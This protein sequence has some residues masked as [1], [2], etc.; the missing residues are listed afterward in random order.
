MSALIPILNQLYE[1]SEKLSK[2]NLMD[3]FERNLNRMR[4][5][6]EE[7]GYIYSDP[8]DEKYTESRTDVDAN[9][10]GSPSNNMKVTQVIKPIIYHVEN[11]VK[12]LVQKGVVMV[13]AK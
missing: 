13:E 8:L 3:K 11:G 1:I 9:I 6:C 7:N 5:I 12:T 10:I 2:E 4:N